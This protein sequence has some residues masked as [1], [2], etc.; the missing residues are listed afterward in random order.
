MTD[1]GD[2]EK[3]TR[4]GACLP[5]AALGTGEEGG[6]EVPISHRDTEATEGRGSR[7]V[8][9][10]LPLEDRGCSVPSCSQLIKSWTPACPD[11]T[12]RLPAPPGPGCSPL[13]KVLLHKAARYVLSLFQLFICLPGC[14]F[15]LVSATLL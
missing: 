1:T 12:A 11:P 4:W 6:H 14:S 15:P 8:A 7:E 2:A 13:M 5:P 9:I 3:T 10:K